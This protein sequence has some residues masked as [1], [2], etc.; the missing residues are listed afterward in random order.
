LKSE[1]SLEI[2]SPGKFV[3]TPDGAYRIAVDF[4]EDCQGSVETFLR[5]K[6]HIVARYAGAAVGIR[7]Y[8]GSGSVAIPTDSNR[9][10]VRYSSAESLRISDWIEVIGA[11]DF[12]FCPNL[13]E[14][15]TSLQQEVGGVRDCRNLE[16]VELSRSIEVIGKGT[17]S[18][19]EDRDGRRT[20]VQRARRW[21]FLTVGDESWLRRRRQGCQVFIAGKDQ[22]KEER[23]QVSLSRIISHL[24]A[25]CGGKVHDMGVVEITASSVYNIHY[26]HYAADLGIIGSHF[27][28]ENKPG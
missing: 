1:D 6:R 25:K 15:I 13:R 21:L 10:F 23:N 8:I 3:L 28:S 9:M 27:I 2:A 12:H 4:A 11:D 16:H 7:L 19:D 26:P 18:V 22:G 5:I 24:T 14:V 17:F 20:G